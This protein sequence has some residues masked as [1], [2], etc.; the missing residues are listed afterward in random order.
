[1]NLAL[2]RA[3]VTLGLAAAILGAITIIYG[4]VRKRSDLV[5]LGRWYV[6]LVFVGGLLAVIAMESAL[7]T[8]N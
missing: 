6:V 2:G 1:M 4:L 3:G 8:R 7:I 5:R